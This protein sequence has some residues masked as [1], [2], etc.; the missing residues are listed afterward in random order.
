[1]PVEE[2][3]TRREEEVARAYAEGLTHKEIAEQLC[4]AP[5]TVRTHLNSIYRK[6]N[7]R[8]KVELVRRID[9][10]EVTPDSPPS[11]RL[12]AWIGHLQLVVAALLGGLVVLALLAVDRSDPAVSAST[13]SQRTAGVPSVAVL[14]VLGPGAGTAA[15][16]SDFTAWLARQI[17]T[18][19]SQISTVRVFSTDSVI[20]HMTEGMPSR[21]IADLLGA[22]HVVAVDARWFGDVILVG[23]QL[24]DA[25]TA[26]VLWATTI[27]K[28]EENLHVIHG[29][30]VDEVVALVGRADG[31]L[32]AQLVAED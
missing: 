22:T 32:G 9:A 10:V 18:G 31:P 30:V 26:E 3:L 19:L 6:L 21:E 14:P 28:R 15:V 13:P 1:M 24:Q 20:A 11:Q 4:V 12:P 17:V 29:E 7:V 16:Q 5:A 23:V 27:E 25:T 2:T 8:T